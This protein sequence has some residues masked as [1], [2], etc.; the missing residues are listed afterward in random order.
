MDDTINTISYSDEHG[1][2]IDPYDVNQYIEDIVSEIDNNFKGFKSPISSMIQSKNNG[3]ILISCWDGNVYAFK[4]PNL[5]YFL[6]YDE[7]K[8]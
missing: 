1:Y 6:F 4:Q 8:K 3:D 5:E 7:Q 2:Y